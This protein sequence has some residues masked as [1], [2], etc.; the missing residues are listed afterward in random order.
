[1]GTRNLT[2]V[3][4]NNEIKIAQYGQWDGYLEGAGATIFD[5][6]KNLIRNKNIEKF[7]ENVRN[8]I[9][10]DRSKIRD[11]Y[12]ELG[13]DIDKTDWIE[14]SI[15]QEYAKRHP[16]LNRDL[17]ADILRYIMNNGPQELKNEIDFAKQSLFCEWGYL[18]N[19]DKETLEI[20]KGFQEE[21]LD[22]SER[23]FYLQDEKCNKYYPIKKVFELPFNII[24]GIDKK[25]F[26][27]VCNYNIYGNIEH[28]E[29]EE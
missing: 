27:N 4:L 16:Q 21:P 29:N 15:S 18:V 19:L 14:Y 7:K 8:C 28:E 24:V 6:L 22:E 25:S 23:F 12:L 5:F 10:I 20:Y 1:M 2:M 13:V 9:I 11:Y 26:L 3:Q 17:G